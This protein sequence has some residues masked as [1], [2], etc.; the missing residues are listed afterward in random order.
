MKTKNPA[1]AGFFY[2]QLVS[3]VDKGENEDLYIIL[4][5]LTNDVQRKGKISVSHSHCV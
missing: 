1:E 2:K 5:A 4:N 3:R